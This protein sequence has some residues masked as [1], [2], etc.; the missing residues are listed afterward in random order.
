MLIFRDVFLFSALLL[1]AVSPVQLVR[2][3]EIGGSGSISVSV[4]VSAGGTAAVPSASASTGVNFASGG[5]NSIGDGSSRSTGVSSVDGGF[6]DVVPVYAAGAASSN[7]GGGVPSSVV[8][9]VAHDLLHAMPNFTLPAAP[10]NPF[11]KSRDEQLAK[12]VQQATQG[13][14][15]QL[16]TDPTHGGLGQVDVNLKKA[17]NTRPDII[18]FELT[19]TADV[20]LESWLKYQ[21]PTQTAVSNGTDAGSNFAFDFRHRFD[22]I[23]LFD[24]ASDPASLGRPSALNIKSVYAVGQPISS[25]S[26][27]INTNGLVN[28]W[29]A[30]TFSQDPNNPAVSLISFATKDNVFQVLA[31]VTTDPVPTST[32]ILLPNSIKFD[33]QIKFPY[34]DG[35]HSNWEIALRARYHTALRLRYHRGVDEVSSNDTATSPDI[36]LS[37][38]K[39][40]VQTWVPTALADGVVVN[41]TSTDFSAILITD[42]DAFPDNDGLWVRRDFVFNVGKPGVITWDPTTLVSDTNLNTDTSAATPARTLSIAA[43]IV[44]AGISLISF[45]L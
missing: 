11:S 15:V 21:A 34:P 14:I 31:R 18:R 37:A 45:L 38:G 33:Y 26:V 40:I 27:N 41:V 32:G 25:S 28:G 6:A 12:I 17:N 35:A 9:S 3:S 8:V 43:G 5:S 42:A 30:P 7:A 13:R 4:S 29:S 20:G 19:S 10:P 22:R 44:A 16:D 1:S 39:S 36:T 24:P 23:V 2:S